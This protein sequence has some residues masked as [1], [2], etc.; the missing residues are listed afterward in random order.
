MLKGQSDY[1]RGGYVDVLKLHLASF[2]T[3]AA[4]RGREGI[5]DSER[6][7]EEDEPVNRIM[8]SSG[9]SEWAPRKN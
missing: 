6:H 8:S 2:L 9:H 3:L 1:Q 4:H 5:V 7:L